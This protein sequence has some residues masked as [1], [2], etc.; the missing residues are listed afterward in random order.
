MKKIAE[1]GTYMQ[2]GNRFYTRN[3]T[4]KDKEKGYLY[5]REFDRI[6]IRNKNPEERS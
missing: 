3:I 6:V 1:K 2:G 5:H 4:E